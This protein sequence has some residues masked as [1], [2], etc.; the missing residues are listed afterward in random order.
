MVGCGN[1]TVTDINRG[2]T[3]RETDFEGWN[4]SC[5]TLSSHQQGF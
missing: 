1:Y 4:G 3:M 2:G 5:R